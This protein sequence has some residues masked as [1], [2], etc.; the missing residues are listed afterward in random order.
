MRPFL[1][2]AFGAMVGIFTYLALTT[3]TPT[4]IVVERYGPYTC[5]IGEVLGLATE[6]QKELA[7]AHCR[8]RS[9]YASD[10][11]ALTPQARRR[12]GFLHELMFGV[13]SQLCEALTVSKP[14]PTEDGKYHAI[15]ECRPTTRPGD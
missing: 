11:A 9:A 4:T 5:A 7:L 12:A 6:A 15:V 2:G 3:S 10:H 1:A 14:V 13:L 8:A